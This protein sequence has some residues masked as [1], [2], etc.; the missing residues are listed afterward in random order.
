MEKIP[1]KNSAINVIANKKAAQEKGVKSKQVKSESLPIWKRN[2]MSYQEQPNE[3]K[4]KSLLQKK[5]YT[6]S[7]L[8]P[9]G[10]IQTAS[11]G[12][13]ILKMSKGASINTALP[14]GF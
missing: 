1:M 7:T 11:K 5:V 4:K 6:N 10:S 13:K 12:S 14:V 2:L 8:A 9:L 3:V